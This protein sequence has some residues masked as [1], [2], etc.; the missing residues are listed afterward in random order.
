MT[1][2]EDF[3]RE[4]IKILDQHLEDIKTHWQ[5]HEDLVNK[6]TDAGID[7]ELMGF[8]L[9]SESKKYEREVEKITGVSNDT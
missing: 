1:T 5:H 7:T 3:K 4:L 2:I 9:I 6:A 8:V